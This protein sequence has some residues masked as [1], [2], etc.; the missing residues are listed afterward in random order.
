MRLLVSA[1]NFAAR[2]IDLDPA[3][4]GPHRI[5]LRRPRTVTVQ[6]PDGVEG[7]QF[8][9]LDAAGL[10]FDD[11][12]HSGTMRYGV[13]KLAVDPAA[14]RIEAFDGVTGASLGSG[15]VPADGKLYLSAARA[16]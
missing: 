2:G 7:A 14:A 3:A 15:L 1:D 6:L 9:V 4:P 8:R 11:D 5:E 16:K 13:G 10:P 12:R